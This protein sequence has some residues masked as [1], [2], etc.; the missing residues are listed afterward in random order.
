ML[1]GLR[2]LAAAVTAASAVAAGS[3]TA[4]AA[5]PPQAPSGVIK[6]ELAGRTT[7]HWK[8]SA[9]V[10][11]HSSKEAELPD[12]GGTRIYSKGN[13]A[14]VRL[15]YREL[16]KDHCAVEA[17]SWTKS[18]SDGIFG[19]EQKRTRPPGTDHL[20][21]LT[22][23]PVLLR[24]ATV[25]YLASD[26]ESTLEFNTPSLSGRREIR[27]TRT[28]P[29]KVQRL[30]IRCDGPT[31]IACDSK[32]GYGGSRLRFGGARADVGKQGYV[33]SFVVNAEGSEQ[34]PSA[35]PGVP[36]AQPLGLL[37]CVYTKGHPVSEASDPAQHP[38]GCDLASASGGNDPSY[39]AYLAVTSVYPLYNGRQV[40]NAYTAARGL[41][42]AGYMINNPVNVPVPKWREAWGIWFPYAY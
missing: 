20:R 10:L 7:I 27:L 21:A 3:I 39:A 28:W 5:T 24:G 42:Y 6:L 23:P 38:T 8:G 1:A 41:S 33:E 25:L 31:V 36:H 37:A 2:R 22:S 35:V 19:P 17:L 26:G 18:V 30:P 16:C 13:Y 12:P 15:D 29:M 11:L 32:D 34:V 9:V 4:H 40:S 14:F